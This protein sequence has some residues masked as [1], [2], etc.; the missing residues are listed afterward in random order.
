M[1]WKEACAMDRRVEFVAA[2]NQRA[3]TISELCEEFGISRKTG[4]KWLTRYRAEGASGLRERSHAPHRV[5]W[6]ITPAQ[7]QAL[8]AYRRQHATLG[9]KKIRAELAVLAPTVSWP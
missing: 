3:E 8:L 4:Y 6:A 2:C 1:P 9:P 5:P 7:A